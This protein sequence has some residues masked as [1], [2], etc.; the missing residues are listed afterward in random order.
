MVR[1]LNR[2]G[3]MSHPSTREKLEFASL[4]FGGHKG[5][6][7]VM[8]RSWDSRNGLQFFLEPEPEAYGDVAMKKRMD[9]ANEIPFQPEPPN[10]S[11]LNEN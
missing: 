11:D 1:D 7:G 10:M 6:G 4:Q 8:C 5:S 2:R 9:D 3:F